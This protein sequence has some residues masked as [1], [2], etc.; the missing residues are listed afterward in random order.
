M[1]LQF[2]EAK[3]LAGAQ[4]GMNQD[5]GNEPGIPFKEAIGQGVSGSFPHSLLR[6]V[7][8]K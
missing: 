1:E 8:F 6:T 3:K 7:L 2:F 5:V 4:S